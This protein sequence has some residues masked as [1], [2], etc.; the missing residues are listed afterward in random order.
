MRA[1][2]LP[3]DAA[4]PASQPAPSHGARAEMQATAQPAVVRQRSAQSEKSAQVRLRQLQTVLEERKSVFAEV[5]ANK[6]AAFVEQQ[7]REWDLATSQALV[8][9]QEM[10][11]VDRRVSTARGRT[12]SLSLEMEATTTDRQ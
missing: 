1:L 11:D 7:I 4:T 12:R 9:L 3:Q 8:Q 2:P 5:S 10:T 6:K